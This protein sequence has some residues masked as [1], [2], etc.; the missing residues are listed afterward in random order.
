MSYSSGFAREQQCSNVGFLVIRPTIAETFPV[1]RPLLGACGICGIQPGDTSEFRLPFATIT[2]LR[3]R[4][5]ANR[6]FVF[7]VEADTYDA[8]TGDFI[9]V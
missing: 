6:L 9:E 4:F 2:A 7:Q 5:P 3:M 8:E 1:S